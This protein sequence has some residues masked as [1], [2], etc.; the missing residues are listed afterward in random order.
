MRKQN[1]NCPR[2]TKIK[3]MCEEYIIYIELIIPI[4]NIYNF[5][6]NISTRG[7]PRVNI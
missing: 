7:V 3:I 5:L 4:K 1:M 2:F 6:M